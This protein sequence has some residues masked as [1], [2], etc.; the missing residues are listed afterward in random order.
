MKR[1]RVYSI[2]YTQEPPLKHKIGASYWFS[3]AFNT[4]LS[5][6]V[7]KNLQED[8]FSKKIMNAEVAWSDKNDYDDN[9]KFLIYIVRKRKKIKEE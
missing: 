9:L 6:A 5:L 8:S 4:A 1:F 7:E 3:N 2:D